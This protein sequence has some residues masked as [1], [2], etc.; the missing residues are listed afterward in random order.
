MTRSL[1]ILLTALVILGASTMPVSGNPFTGGGRPEPTPA[2]PPAVA[3]PG[4]LLVKVA[5]WQQALRAEMAGRIRQAR[6]ENSLA[7]LAVVLVFAFVYGMLHAAGPGHGKAVAMSFMLS[8]SASLGR[9]LFFGTL[10]AVFHGLSGALL[11]VVL[12]FAIH[13]AVTGPLAE[14]SRVTQTVSYGLIVLLGFGL[15]VR[16]GYAL[17]DGGIKGAAAKGG[18]N[19]RPAGRSDSRKSLVFWAFGVGM[20]PCPG[21]VMVMLFCLS[22][23][24]SGLGLL[25]ALFISLGM[26]VTLSFVVLAV[27]VVGRGASLT[28]FPE[29]R[30][31]GCRKP[32][33]PGFGSGHQRLSEFFFCWPPRPDRSDSAHKGA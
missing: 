15:L 18:Q 24:M 21:V 12:R 9:G 33:G 16:H 10:I 2:P 25:S 8:Q 13:S 19:P 4:G 23:G 32:S 14:V 29:T 20:V 1:A 7:P 17:L 31:R 30:R 5:L 22:L 11:V 26:A 6:S 28:L 3:A 27:V